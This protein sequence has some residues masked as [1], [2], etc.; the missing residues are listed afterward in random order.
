MFLANETRTSIGV[1]MK[2]EGM[3]PLLLSVSIFRESDGAKNAIMNKHKICMHI[4]KIHMASLD[5]MINNSKK[6]WY[7]GD[8][9]VYE[10]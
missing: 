3:Q 8:L 4:I 5:H 10:I 6:N 1:F 7:L 9:A 2:A